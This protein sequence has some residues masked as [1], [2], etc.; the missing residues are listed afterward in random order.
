M[1]SF[2]AIKEINASLIFLLLLKCYTL[3][4]NYVTCFLWNILSVHLSVCSLMYFIVILDFIF[5]LF[6]STLLL[7]VANK[8]YYKMLLN[9]CCTYLTDGLSKFLCYDQKK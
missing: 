4:R 1:N 5:F 8:D 3:T 9:A 7:F 6:F 2:N